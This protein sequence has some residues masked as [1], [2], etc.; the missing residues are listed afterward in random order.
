MK[1]KKLYDKNGQF[2]LVEPG[3]QAEDELKAIGYSEKTPRK[4]KLIEKA[5]KAE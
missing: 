4:K 5:E 1:L 2:A 3:S